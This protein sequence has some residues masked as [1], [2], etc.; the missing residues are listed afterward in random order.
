MMRLEHVIRLVERPHLALSVAAAAIRE[1]RVCVGGHIITEPSHQVLLGAEC[2]ELDGEELDVSRVFS[3][4]LLFHK[5]SGNVCEGHDSSERSIFRLLMPEQQHPQLSFF[6]RLD[7]DT[8]GLMILGTD[9]GIGA[10]LTDPDSR[11]AKEY[12]A[13]LSGL[14]PLKED[15]VQLIASGVELSDGKRCLPAVLSFGPGVH[16][17]FERMHAQSA[18]LHQRGGQ[19]DTH[20]ELLEAVACVHMG[21]STS[22]DAHGC[23]F[24][25]SNQERHRR[26]HWPSSWVERAEGRPCVSVVL[27]EGMH[28]QVKRML[29]ACNGCVLEL[30]REA[31]GP[32]RLS[33]LDPP[34]PEGCAR[35]PSKEE[36][37]TILELLPEARDAK[38]RSPRVHER[39]HAKREWHKK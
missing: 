19:V 3:R 9:G 22:V 34:I 2:L 5:P 33:A 15:A 10:L 14:V 25:D 1:G 39:M 12:W 11:V 18:K 6:G 37:R 17:G 23:R 38:A 21:D 30:H 4:M 24:K 27:H 16:P 13:I 31:I 28:H 26:H 8:T 7:R 29:G 32:L 20:A 35:P 36:L